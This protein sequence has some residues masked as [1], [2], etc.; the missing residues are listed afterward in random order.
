[1]HLLDDSETDFTEEIQ[2]ERLRKQVVD[3]IRANQ[4]LEGQVHELDTKI[5]LIL[6][7]K[8]SFEELVRFKGLAG[9][10]PAAARDSESFSFAQTDPFS[11]GAQLDK[12]TRKRLELYQHMFFLL[13]T[14]PRYLAKLF[15]LLSTT[16]LDLQ[17]AKKMEDVILALYGYGQGRR[18]DFLM[19]KLLQMAVHEEILGSELEELVEARPFVTS[20]AL[21]YVRPKQGSALKSIFQKAVQAILNMPNLD[22]S[23]DPVAVSG[24]CSPDDVCR[25][26]IATSNYRSTID[27]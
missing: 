2:V 17:Q 3:H 26:L 9:A 24:L 19:H 18:E 13:Q 16:P 4:A 15:R 25:A 8:L 7:N 10:T 11:H 20:V 14:E 12:G 27:S 22:L 6:Q 23:T 21:A 1:M 5:A